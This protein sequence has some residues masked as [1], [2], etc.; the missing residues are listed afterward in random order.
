MNAAEEFESSQN[1]SLRRA[2]LKNSWQPQINTKTA[3]PFLV[4]FCIVFTILSLVLLILNAKIYYAEYDYTDCHNKLGTDVNVQDN[5]LCTVNIDIPKRTLNTLR[6]Y[7]KIKNM[8]QNQ[9]LYAESYDF[10]QQIGEPPPVKLSSSCDRLAKDGNMIINPCGLVPNSMFNDTF[11][12]TINGQIRKLSTKN[13]ITLPESKIF[14]NPENMSYVLAQFAKPPDWRKPIY[15]LD[16]NDSNNNGFQ[17]TAYITWMRIYPFPDVLKQLGELDITSTHGTDK[18][19]K[20]EVK[21]QDNYPVKG[22]EGRKILIV[23]EASWLGIP[24]AKLGYIYCSASIISFIFVI[25]FWISTYLVRSA[26]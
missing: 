15:E 19:L 20:L 17:N 21:I 2:I 1:S 12:F 3:F 22:F 8:Y 7:Y 5:K 13:L 24:N 26:V 4:V 11:E 25:Y 18:S 10:M 6:F 23:V 14:K 16:P 9:R